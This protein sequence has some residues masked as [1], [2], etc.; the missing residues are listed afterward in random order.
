MS[1]GYISE[2]HL[3]YGQYSVSFFRHLADHTKLF[4]ITIMG[5]GSFV[6]PLVILARTTGLDLPKDIANI[7]NQSDE[8]AEIK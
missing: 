8:Y 1:I 7:W 5:D 6:I 3:E 4:D 2:K